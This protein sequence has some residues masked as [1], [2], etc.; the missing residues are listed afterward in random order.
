MP[1]LFCEQEASTVDGVRMARAG[2][3]GSLM[4]FG[5]RVLVRLVSMKGQSHASSK[6]TY[7][8]R[9]ANLNQ[10]PDCDMESKAYLHS[11]VEPVLSSRTADNKESCVY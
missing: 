2:M 4:A 11:E 6:F 5:L 7:C 3:D 9:T 1:P 10:K 8:E